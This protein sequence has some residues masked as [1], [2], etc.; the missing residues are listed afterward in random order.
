MNYAEALEELHALYRFGIYEGLERITELL[1]RLGN[2]QKQIPH[3][4]H[5]AGTNGKGSVSAMLSA[6]AQAAGKK[7]ALF[8]SPHLN[9][10][11][12]RF[13]INGEMI[14]EERFVDVFS[15]VMAALHQMVEEG[16]ES[17]TEFEAAT[18]VAYLWF[19]QE[20]VDVAVVEVGLGGDADATNVIL[21]DVSVITNVGLDH[22]LHLGNTVE[23]IA[24]KKAG[25]IKPHIPVVTAATGEALTVLREKAREMH[26]PLA[27]LGE[28]IQIQKA[29]VTENGSELDLHLPEGEY[30]ELHVSLLGLYQLENAALAVAAAVKAGFSKQA[31]AQGLREARWPGR[32]EKLSEQPLVVVDGAHNEPGMAALSQAVEAF[33]PNKRILGIL[34]ML[35]DKQREEALPQLLKWLD[36]A[37]VTPPNNP[38]R[39]GDWET[40]AEI[41]RK[42]GVE[43]EIEADNRKACAEA[44]SL[45]AEGKYD[46]L[47]AAGS[48]YLIADLRLYLLDEL[49]KR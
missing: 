42:A 8:T 21:P 44:M 5:I 35:G 19:A 11:R 32:L 28:E 26:A 14:G 27:V 9:C 17:P 7:T 16:W 43:A 33:W 3:M 47:L 48:L 13:R 40:I 22:L 39:A 23:K 36:Y 4:I 30:V 12:E 45:L 6:I 46:M 38:S 25:I 24:H 29:K 10:H 1:R 49:Q 18:A 20:Q 37:I 34:G 31:I 15:Q 2:P 41:C